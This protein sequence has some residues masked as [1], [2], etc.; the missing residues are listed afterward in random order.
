MFPVSDLFSFAVTVALKAQSTTD[1]ATGQPSI[2]Q[3]YQPRG[4]SLDTAAAMPG[5][6]M[7]SSG[8]ELINQDLGGIR[9]GGSNE[10]GMPLYSSVMPLA[11]DPPQTSYNRPQQQQQQQQHQSQQGQPRQGQQN[12]T[13]VI[14]FSVLFALSM[15]NIYCVEYKRSTS[16]R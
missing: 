16:G 6:M 15:A 7:S 12:V 4:P 8:G 11:A 9:G 5:T 10:V 3:Q 14:Y 2:P 13:F 1:V